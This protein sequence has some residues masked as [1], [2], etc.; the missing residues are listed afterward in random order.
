[1]TEVTYTFR[2]ERALR[3]AF[4]AMAEEQ[5]LTA[6]QI[7]R[8]LMREAVDQYREAAAHEKWTRSEIG[9]AMDIAD[10][11][12]APRLSSAAVEDEWELHREEI[13]RRDDE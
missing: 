10:S 3:E 4:V 7:L 11:P 13:K 12:S 5:D 9:A 8:R 2:V 6:A 1:M